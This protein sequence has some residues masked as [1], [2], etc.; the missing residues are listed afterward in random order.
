MILADY[1]SKSTTPLDSI[2]AW[3]KKKK[4]DNPWSDPSGIS[5]T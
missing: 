1:S 2:L 5:M 3:K 4:E